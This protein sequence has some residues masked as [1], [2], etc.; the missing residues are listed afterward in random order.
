MLRDFLS[1]EFPDEISTELCIVG[2]GAAGITLAKQLGSR[3]Q[4]V[5]LIEG[6]GQHIND[7]SQELFSGESIGAP[8]AVGEGRYRVFGGSTL[9]WRGRCAALDP[10]DFEPREWVADSGWPIEPAEIFDYYPD[11]WKWCGF[12]EA[13]ENDDDVLRKRI[14]NAMGRHDVPIHPYVWRFAPTGRAKYQNWATR[15]GSWLKDSENVTVLLNANATSLVASPSNDHVDAV[16]ITSTDGRSARIRA[17]NF[18]FACGG[19]ENPRLALNFAERT[20][21]LFAAV[22]ETLGGY[23]MQHPKA[24]TAQIIPEEGQEIRLQRMFNIFLQPS[25]TQYELGLALSDKVQ[26]D[27][28][29]LNCSGHFRY[30]EQPGSGWWHAKSILSG[31]R[32]GSA[33]GSHLRGMLANPQR[34]P[35]NAL[36][37]LFG[38]PSLLPSPD[39]IF[40]TEVEQVPDRDSRVFLQEKRDCLG[41]RKAGLDWRIAEIEHKTALSFTELA[42]A[43]LRR[44]G[45][46]RLQIDE[47]LQTRGVM[48]HS[49]L[50]ESYHH[51]GATR[52][53]ETA[54]AGVVNGDSAVHG[55]A[56]LYFTGS[57]VMPTGG[58]VNPTLTI[59]ALALRLADHLARKGKA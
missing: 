50:R 36:R 11:A 19:I 39:A 18:V 44:M 32:A 1:S 47:D 6:G 23:F 16:E 3:G 45:F 7:T 57:S 33:M 41:L 55:V 54:R 34:L 28:Q 20:P 9:R 2:A 56:N 14:G 24:V 30:T 42:D 49:Q 22:G 25:G 21:G 13:M 29:L 52:M 15:F 59:V 46:G 58:H 48:E 43:A 27:Q 26:R 53:S 4:D 10:I 51:I 31:N 38:R 17:R 37:R 8:I 35:H 5:I 12:S 40:V